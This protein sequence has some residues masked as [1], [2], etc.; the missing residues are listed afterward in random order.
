ML[1][2]LRVT[3][4]T[5]LKTHASNVAFTE[6][7]S[8]SGGIRVVFSSLT[9]NVDDDSE[10]T[11]HKDRIVINFYGSV[12]DDIETLAE[13]VFDDFHENQKNWSMTT[14]YITEIRNEINRTSKL[15]KIY[16]ITHQYLFDLEHK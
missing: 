4:Q 8:T 3:I 9:G 6:S 13:A 1:K 7:K 14:Y 12:L 11:Y 15:D 2:E 16:M 5:R 10:N